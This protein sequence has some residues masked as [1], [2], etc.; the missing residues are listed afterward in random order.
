MRQFA[1]IHAVMDEMVQ[2]LA[3]LRALAADEHV[4][5]AAE[6]AGV[7]QPTVSRW[8][9]ALGTTL[10]APVV[11]R[12]GRRVRLTRAGRLLCEAADR[13]LTALEAGQRAAAEEVSPERGQVALGFLQPLDRLVH[14]LDDAGQ[15]DAD[16]PEQQQRGELGAVA[17]HQAEPRW[18]VDVADR[19]R[20]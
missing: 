15:Q 3:V 4:T 19:E 14:G 20:R 11:I 5:H 17:D 16:H 1:I 12:S 10:G 7:P 8:L 6:A 2:R 9:A 18:H 13:A